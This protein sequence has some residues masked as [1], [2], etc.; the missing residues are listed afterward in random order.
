MAS[1]SPALQNLLTKNESY[2]TT[3]V[4][5]PNLDQYKELLNVNPSIPRVCII[6][7][8]DPRVIPEQIFNLSMGDALVIRVGGGNIQPALPTLLA[9]D[10]EIGITDVMVMRHTDCGTRRWT[11]DKVRKAL[12]ERSDGQDLVGRRGEK[13]EDMNFCESVGDME[14]LVK[15]DVEWLKHSPLVTEDTK[16]SIVGAMY[17]V[18]T[19]KVSVLC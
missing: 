10:T 5:M 15:G 2:V 1:L 14:E 19:G 18:D 4:A 6:T 3:H 7:C 8:A 16:K 11:D 12:R 9:L 17:H 13:L